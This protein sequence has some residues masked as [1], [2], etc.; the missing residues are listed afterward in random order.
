MTL[1][2]DQWRG[3]GQSNGHDLVTRADPGSSE[4]Q[5]AWFRLGEQLPPVRP[6][7]AI[8]SRAGTATPDAHN[9]HR[10]TTSGR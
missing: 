10:A 5:P 6:E 4:P 7:D 1:D 3:S 9:G 2:L 8:D